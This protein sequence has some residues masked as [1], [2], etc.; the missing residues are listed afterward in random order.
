MLVRYPKACYGEKIMSSEGSYRYSAPDG[1]VQEVEK[2][3]EEQLL[4]L[5]RRTNSVK[6]V[7]LVGNS[8]LV[9]VESRGD[10]S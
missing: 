3:S 8:Q 9:D 2:L 6:A 10:E 5:L 7:Q 1:L 4:D